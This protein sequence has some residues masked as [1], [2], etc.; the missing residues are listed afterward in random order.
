MDTGVIKTIKDGGIA[1]IPT[2][3]VYGI[4]GSAL[5]KKTVERIYEVRKRTPSKPLII[6]IPSIASLKK[7]SI[8]DIPTSILKSLWP[9]KLT[10]ILPCVDK[11]FEYLH[12]GT[13]TLAFRLPKDKTLIALLKKTG[14]LVAPSA[15]IEG[16]KPSETITDA[17]AYFGA[18]VDIYLDQGPQRGLPSTIIEIKGQKGIYNVSLIREGAVSIKI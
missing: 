18:D 10:I 6:L 9:D 16:K 17:E 1:V 13:S 15:N 14:P 8:K 12:R 4:V 7:F 3:T 11:K 2:D 5:N